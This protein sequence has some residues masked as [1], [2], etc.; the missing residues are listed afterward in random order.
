MVAYNILR[1]L[2]STTPITLPTTSTSS[3]TPTTP[4]TTTT[5]KSLLLALS[6]H[7]I[8]LM[9]SYLTQRAALKYTPAL[10]IPLWSAVFTLVPF[11]ADPSTHDIFARGCALLEVF[12]RDMRGVRTF[13]RGIL[14]VAWKIGVGIPEAAA[15]ALEGLEGEICS[16]AR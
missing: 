3:T 4:P 11:L 14:A 12:E 8:H 15:E 5:A 7:D 2:P 1:P 16:Y 6:A 13:R 9:H 10:V